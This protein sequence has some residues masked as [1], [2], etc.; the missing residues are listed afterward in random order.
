MA[1]IIASGSIQSPQAI[2]NANNYASERNCPWVQIGNLFVSLTF[3]G[4]KS[5]KPVVE[6]EY[7]LGYREFTILSGRHGDQYRQLVQFS[8]GEF[9][10]GV[11]ERKHYTQ[12]LAEKDDLDERLDDL[13]LQVI[14][15]GRPPHNTLKPLKALAL[16]ELNARRTVIFAWCFSIF[17]MMEH[18]ENPYLPVPDKVLA[19]YMLRA[20]STP[21]AALV[22]EGFSWVPAK[23]WPTVPSVAGA[24]RSAG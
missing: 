19:S 1:N 12:Y 18:P 13:H 2:Y 22:K 4:N 6:H 14:D 5:W 10:P 8:T 3:T 16:S 9:G 11:A 23:K 24:F 20:F 15:V 17:S 7:E 21:V